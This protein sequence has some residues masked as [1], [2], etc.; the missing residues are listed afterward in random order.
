MG[1]LAETHVQK[2]EGRHGRQ[3]ERERN[4]RLDR[5]PLIEFIPPPTPLPS[6]NPSL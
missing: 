3:Q 6:P 2:G 5:R 4:N 1:S